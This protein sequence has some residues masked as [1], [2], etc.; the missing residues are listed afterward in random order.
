MAH[1]DFLQDAKSCKDFASIC[2]STSSCFKDNL[3]CELSSNS[4]I[5]ADRIYCSVLWAPN[6]YVQMANFS[7]LKHALNFPVAQT[8]KN[9]PAMQETRVRSLG[10]EDPLEKGMAIHSSILSW[11]IPWQRSLAGYSSWGCKELDVAEWITHTNMSQKRQRHKCS[12]LV[13]N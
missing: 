11:R 8:V 13:L 5:Y 3:I 4:H 2:F 12:G 9:V 7:V 1:G 6:V 10:W